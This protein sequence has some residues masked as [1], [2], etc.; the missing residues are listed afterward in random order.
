MSRRL[1][2]FALAGA[3]VALF[4]A[5]CLWAADANKVLLRTAYKTGNRY[6]AR[7]VQHND[8]T[9]RPEGAPVVEATQDTS[10]DLAMEVMSVA[11]DG[12]AELRISYERV[13]LKAASQGNAIDYDS[14]DPAKKDVQ[15]PA[16]N[17]LRALLGKSLTVSISPRGE[18]KGVKGYDKIVEA[19]LDQI[20]A[21]AEREATRKQIESTMDEKHFTQMMQG[22]GML[23]PEQSVGVGDTW[24]RE[25]KI[26]TG[27]INI[28]SRMDYKVEKVNPDSIELSVQ[29]KLSSLPS[30]PAAELKVTVEPDSVQAG[31]V[32]V[33]RLDPAVSTSEITQTLNITM[34]AGLRVVRQAVV[35]KVTMT[36]A[37]QPK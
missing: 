29:G 24:V 22:T 28:D 13:T 17:G 23:L 20:P 36:I 30:D 37:R 6:S 9:Q 14:A 10:M 11:A 21:G 4:G 19:I 33:S 8:I 27:I 35:G 31:T 34:S 25:Q 12:T 2:A 3:A 15:A 5:S 32:R 16:V 18:I 26:E 7:M 1:I